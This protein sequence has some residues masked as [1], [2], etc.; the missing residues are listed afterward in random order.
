[1]FD[2]LL[3]PTDGSDGTERALDHV[4][5]IATAHDATLHVLNVADV[6][7]DS[8]AQIQGE[9]IDALVDEGENTVQQVV[10]RAEARDIPTTTA[11]EQG[12]PYPT[13]VEYASSNDVDLVVM[14][15]HG[16]KGLSRL[17]LGSTTER[18][19]R[20]SDVPVLTIGPDDTD[21]SYPYEDI[22]VPTDG[23][24]SAMEALTLGIDLTAVDDGTLHLLSVAEVTE[25]GVGAPGEIQLKIFEEEAAETV[26]AAAEVATEA[27]VERVTETAEAGISVHRAILSYVEKNDVDVIVAGTH[28]RTGFD[29]YML[30]SV[31]EKLVRTAPVPVL[32]VRQKPDDEE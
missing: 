27:G 21:L 32:T 29:R 11:V 17:L 20:E 24:K 28:G 12:E 22:L 19:V 15:T 18:V 26:E 25:F 10:D 3:F 14:P 1:M 30:G 6:T 31:T 4:L 23:S 9:V 5:D 13:I 8:V 7:R 2:D 16:R